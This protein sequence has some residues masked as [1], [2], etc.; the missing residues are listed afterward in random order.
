MRTQV[1]I[2]PFTHLTHPPDLAPLSKGAIFAEICLNWTP[3]LVGFCL[4]SP[5]EG[6]A[7]WREEEPGISSLL[8]AALASISVAVQVR[9]QKMENGSGENSGELGMGRAK[10][11]Q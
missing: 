7:G 5:M 11:L 1:Q 2:P 9:T 4:V 10:S 6:M 3:L 8:P